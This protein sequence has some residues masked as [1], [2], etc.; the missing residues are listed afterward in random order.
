M[1]NKLLLCTIVAVGGIASIIAYAQRSARDWK[2]HDPE[3]A[4]PTVI[5]PGTESSQEQPGAAPSDAVVLFDGKD[6]S[7]WQARDGT[8]PAWQVENGEMVAAGSDIV[9]KEAFGDCQVHIEWLAPDP[10]TGAGQDKGNS[11]IKMMG[12]YEVQVLDSYQNK[13]KTYA[14]GVAGAI[15]GQY[16]PLVNASRPPGQWQTFDIAFFAPRRDAEGKVID[17][18]RITVFHNGVLIHHNA[19]ILGNTSGP[20][21]E[22]KEHAEKEPL[23]LQFHGHPVR[24]RNIWV[25]P[26]QEEAR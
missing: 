16:P 10:D 6:L 13:N 19:E 4:L 7:Q 5:D 2:V 3:R 11:G 20:S 9:S 23:L 14:D 1:Q 8:D 26:L 15:Y 12:H 25:R 22:Y 21:R 18:A 17:P 24:F